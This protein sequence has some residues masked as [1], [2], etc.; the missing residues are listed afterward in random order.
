MEARKLGHAV[1]RTGAMLCKAVMSLSIALSL[2]ACAT[3][4]GPK[5][6]DEVEPR[7]SVSKGESLSLTKTMWALPVKQTKQLWSDCF[8]SGSAWHS[9]EAVFLCPGIPLLPVMG[10][11]I[12]GLG[13][14]MW[15]TL[16]L[17]TGK[18]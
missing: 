12:V 10:V 8:E 17:L 15:I 9:P 16:D 6:S 3:A 4:T 7:V 13:T 1:S 11:A 5:A 14:P 2:G 18:R